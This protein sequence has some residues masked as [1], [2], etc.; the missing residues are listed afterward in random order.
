MTAVVAVTTST[1]DRAAVVALSALPAAGPAR[2]RALLARGPAAEQWAAIAAGRLRPDPVLVAACAGTLVDDLLGRWRAAAA[3]I[4]PARLLARHQAAGVG[5]LVA[6]DPAWPP[7]LVDD[8]DPPAVLFVRGDPVHLAG[9]VPA[10]A[11]VGTRNC[12]RYGWDVAHRL[13][14]DLAR[15][16]VTVVSGLASGIDGAAHRGAIDQGGAAPIGVV[17]SG[18]DVV[19]PRGHGRLWREVADIGMLVSEAPLGVRPTRWR[20]PARNR[21]IAALSGVVVVVESA[22]TGGAMHTVDEAERRDRPVLA[23]PGPVTSAVSAG[24]NRLLADGAAPACDADDVL[25]ALDVGGGRSGSTSAADSA[26]AA[27]EPVPDGE[28]GRLLEALG[29]RPATLDQLVLRT[30]LGLARTAGL[31]AELE[32]DGWIAADGGWFER[33][34]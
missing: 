19:Y 22:V 7:A 8:P 21:I 29:W 14:A 28:A 18:L 3:T 15:A 13:G 6:G 26:D 5:V 31:A 25:L 27:A 1:D 32:A 23:V 24:T 4:D 33:C 34:R 2:I 17:A 16:G 9:S 10:A 11:V 12:S 20:F 30:G